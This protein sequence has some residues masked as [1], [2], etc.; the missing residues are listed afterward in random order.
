L[1]CKKRVAVE[2]NPVAAA[3]ARENGV[4]VYT[5]GDLVPDDYVDVVITCHALE[6]THYP[7]KELEGLYRKVRKGGKAVIVV[8]CESIR[9]KYKKDD[10]DQH[11]YTW[12][13]MSIGNLCKLAGFN[14]IESRPFIHFG[15]G[16][17]RNV[18]LKVFGW[19]GYHFLCRIHGILGPIYQVRV[20]ATK[21]A[22]E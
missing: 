11:L 19:K 22:E 10:V 4:E 12:S 20:I 6:H 16:G 9:W 3:V 13:P 5:T 17:I 21:P 1:K 2:I 15:F 7:L 8:P 18:L 14:V